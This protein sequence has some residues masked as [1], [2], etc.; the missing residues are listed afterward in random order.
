[1]AIMSFKMDN[2]I[3]YKTL[4]EDKAYTQSYKNVDRN[5]IYNDFN[6]DDGESQLNK[7][8]MLSDRNI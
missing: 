7:Y 5:A 4:Y 6:T 3:D 2:L 8:R 1:M